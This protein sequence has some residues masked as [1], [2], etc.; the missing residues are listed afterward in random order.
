MDR[1]IYDHGVTDGGI[2]SQNSPHGLAF[3]KLGKEVKTGRNVQNPWGVERGDGGFVE[4][5]CI[6]LYNFFAPPGLSEGLVKV[7]L[8]NS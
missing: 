3:S 2:P 8:H 6:L 7:I 4:S 1:L 5:I